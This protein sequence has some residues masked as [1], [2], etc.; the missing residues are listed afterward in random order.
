MLA[1]IG[2]GLLG[3]LP[4]RE[5]LRAEAVLQPAAPASAY[6]AFTKI[7][8]AKGAKIFVNQAP[9]AVSAASA[10]AANT[11]H[12]DMNMVRA[13]IED[14]I[15]KTRA[16]APL[17][18]QLS[19]LL[20]SGTAVQQVEFV[21]GTGRYYF[22]WDVEDAITASKKVTTASIECTVCETI[23][24]IVCHCAGNGDQFC[25]EKCREICHRH[26]C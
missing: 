19:R 16:N 12:L 15:A 13:S 20:K 2:L 21:M 14:A 5:T 4:F 3:Q 18:T 11:L 10:N 6:D 23:C 8:K 9:P 24:P 17:N 22:P 25:Q 26:S 1:S 7:A